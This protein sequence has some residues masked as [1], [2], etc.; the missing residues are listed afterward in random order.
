MLFIKNVELYDPEYKGRCHVL[1]AGER[2]EA[3]ISPEASGKGPE[4]SD[5]DRALKAEAAFSELKALGA[6]A[7][8]ID[9]EGLMLFPGIVDGHV[10]IT[11][12][13]GEGGFKTRAPEIL[14]SDLIGAGVTTVLGL[15]GTDDMTR[16]TEAL[17]AKAKALT[18]EGITAYALTGAYGYPP[19]T[20]TDSVKKDVTFVSEILGLKLALSDHRAP[21]VT[22]DELIRLASDVRTAGMISG[23]GGFL[24]LHMGDGREGLSKV[25]EALSRTEIPVKLFHPTHVTRKESLFEDAI[26]F[27]KMG[28]YIDLTAFDS[29]NSKKLIPFI[30]RLLSEGVD[31]SLVTVSSDAQGSYSEYDEDGRLLKIGISSIGSIYDEFA[32][33][34]R[35]QA[36]LSLSY[37]EIASLFTENPARALG[38]YPE[39][40]AVREGSDADMI[41]LDSRLKLSCVIAKG[42]VM[43]R[44]GKVLV[45]GTYEDSRA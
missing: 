36:S 2:I 44:D 21:N 17:L 27:A 3:V 24:V 29:H 16:N 13:G 5:T 39:K 23:K 37:S 11:G 15:L 22:E 45:R 26:K 8:I 28:G 43:M 18:E 20:L 12:G 14:L 31:L 42:R 6:E 35:E 41:L 25:F 38:L 30:K 33:L 7:E 40:G 34:L 1:C 4:E 9:G 10:H 32:C 19:V